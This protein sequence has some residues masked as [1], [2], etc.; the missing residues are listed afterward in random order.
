VTDL[1]SIHLLEMPTVVG[2]SK[3][4]PSVAE[5]YRYSRSRERTD[6]VLAAARWVW[7]DPE[8]VVA[9]RRHGGASLEQ[10]RQSAAVTLGQRAMSRSSKRKQ[11]SSQ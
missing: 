4:C 2:G 8:G 10:L 3:S 7:E 9:L 6:V 5:R 1:K 11:Q